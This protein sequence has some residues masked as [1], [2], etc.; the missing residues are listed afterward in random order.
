M[1]NHISIIVAGL[2]LEIFELNVCLMVKLYLALSASFQRILEEVDF[3][4][5]PAECLNDEDLVKAAFVW[6]RDH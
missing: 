2:G 1:V 5:C 6:A 4:C 3:A